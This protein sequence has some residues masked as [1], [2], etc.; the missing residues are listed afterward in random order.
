MMIIKGRLNKLILHQTPTPQP[1]LKT[2]TILQIKI[3]DKKNRM[4]PTGFE[5]VVRVLQT[6]ALPLGHV[7]DF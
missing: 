4:G 5:P 6:L 1:A 7:A 3:S 2:I